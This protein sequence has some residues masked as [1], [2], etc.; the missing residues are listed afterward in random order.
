MTAGQALRPDLTLAFLVWVGVV[1][2]ALN[3]LLPWAEARLFG[4][5]AGRRRR[6]RARLARLASL[7][8]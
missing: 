5:A 4:Q 8:P 2:F 3:Q 7:S 1:G 6:D